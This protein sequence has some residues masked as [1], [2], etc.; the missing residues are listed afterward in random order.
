VFVVLGDA[1]EK[2]LGDELMASGIR[3][4]RSLAGQTTIAEAA[5]IIRKSQMF[6]GLDGGLLHIAAC[7]GKP[8][9]SL[10]GPSNP[11]LYGYERINPIRHRSLSLKLNCAPC[12]AWIDSN[13]SRFPGPDDCPDHRCLFDMSP[14]FVFAEFSTFVHAHALA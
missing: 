3:N 2:Q 1:N 8:T 14:A 6:L 4:I 9:F 10:W 5:G 7:L 13:K 12:S 11:V